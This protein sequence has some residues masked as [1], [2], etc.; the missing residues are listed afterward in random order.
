[1]NLSVTKLEKDLGQIK[2][3]L[4]EIRDR[5]AGVRP[6]IYGLLQGIGWTVGTLA[7]VALIGWL[8]SVSGVVPGLGKIAQ[9]LENILNRTR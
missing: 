6:F 5:S 8:L 1:L 9:D 7:A 3:E 2:E 4:G